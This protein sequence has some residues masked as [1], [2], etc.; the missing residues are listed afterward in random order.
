VIRRHPLVIDTF[1]FNDELDMLELR[2]TEIGDAVDFV[3]AVEADVTHQ[4]ELKPYHLTENLDRFKRWEE[5]LIVVQATNLPT[6]EQAPSAWA[7]EHAQRD[8]IAGGIDEVSQ[9]TPVLSSDI[10]LQSDVDE[11]PRAVYARNVRP[12]GLTAFGQRGHFWAVDWF[13]PEQW[14]G[15][16]AGTLDTIMTR[17]G[18]NP[19]SWMRDS[20]NGMPPPDPSIT[21]TS[22]CPPHMQDAGWHLSWL[23]GPERT[24]KKLSEF[25]HPEAE[26]E[27]AEGLAD[28][29]RFYREGVH[30][31]GLK[32]LPVDVD[33]EWPR[34]IV[35]GHAPSSWY[36]PR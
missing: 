15:T 11:V 16:V 2:L 14:H 23:G 34:W 22:T 7:R 13:Y 6:V 27:I 31:D 21:V 32:M 12:T 19:F 33:E 35:E 10:V 28:E 29:D 25:C 4:G 36:R 20:R 5:K 26:V 18:R 30:V 1:P 9:I 17:C 3:V 24:S 8:W